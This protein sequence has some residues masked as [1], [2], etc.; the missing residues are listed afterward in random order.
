MVGRHEAGVV[1]DWCPWAV[2]LNLVV[3]APAEA[4]LVSGR[5]TGLGCGDGVGIGVDGLLLELVPWKGLMLLEG[6][7]WMVAVENVV[8][9]VLWVL[10][11]VLWWVV[12]W[13]GY[14]VY[15]V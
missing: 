4:A 3:E 5:G 12:L 2:F 8:W 15:C 13:C 14:C 11:M 10:W 9:V 1:G 6:V 7:R